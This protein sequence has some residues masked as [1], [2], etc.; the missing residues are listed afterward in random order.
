MMLRKD[1]W[2][3]HRVTTLIQKNLSIFP[4]TSTPQQIAVPGYCDAV[5]GIPVE[6]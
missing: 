2:K 1:V 3:I 6:S 5:T 4:L